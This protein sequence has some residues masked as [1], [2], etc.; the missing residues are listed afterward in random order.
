LPIL[1]IAGG[2]IVVLALILYVVLGKS[3]AAKQPTAD[4]TT[5]TAEPSAVTPE[6]T[7]PQAIP[8]PNEPERDNNRIDPAAVGRDLE[9]ALKNQRL[10]SSVEVINTVVEVRSGSCRDASMMPTVDAAATALRNAGLTRMRCVEN[11]GA[12]VFERGL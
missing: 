2:A 4:P 1:P 10:W 3:D 12:V 11:S 7:R 9:R 5:P 6:P 8:L